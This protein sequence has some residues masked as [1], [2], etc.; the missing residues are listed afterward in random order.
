MRYYYHRSGKKWA[1]NKKNQWFVLPNDYD[2]NKKK[3]A[4]IFKIYWTKSIKNK[5]Y[6]ALKKKFIN[7]Y[8]S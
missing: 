2:L 5:K 4:D 1:K 3:S 8:Y 6:V 7:V